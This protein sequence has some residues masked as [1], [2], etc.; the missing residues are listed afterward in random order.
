MENLSLYEY[1]EKLK[2]GKEDLHLLG[3]YFRFK[4][5]PRE[6]IKK[7]V[8]GFIDKIEAELM[9]LDDEFA[10]DY[11]DLI[12]I[13]SKH[14][15]KKFNLKCF[16]EV[17]TV[18]EVNEGSMTPNTFYTGRYLM[19]FISEENKFFSFKENDLGYSSLTPAEYAEMLKIT[20]KTNSIVLRGSEDFGLHKMFVLDLA[21]DKNYIQLATQD[22]RYYNDFYSNTTFK[23]LDIINEHLKTIEYTNQDNIFETLENINNHVNTLKDDKKLE[24]GKD[25]GV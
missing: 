14:Y 13:L 8:G 21:K 19:G 5:Y 1:I 24:K 16:R 23:I 11:K 2:K 17:E 18:W 20:N 9:Q 4:E 12:N 6:I 3:K 7:E 15:D 10:I 22:Y 25:L